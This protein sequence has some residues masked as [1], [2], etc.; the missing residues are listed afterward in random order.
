MRPGKIIPLCIATLCLFAALSNV[1]F[2]GTFHEG[3]VTESVWGDNPYYLR[4]NRVKYF[5]EPDEKIFKQVEKQGKWI[6]E[7]VNAKNIQAGDK[8][9]YKVRGRKLYDIQIMP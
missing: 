4:I 6:I 2:A 5:I 8:L 9:L 7:P 3:T 1:G